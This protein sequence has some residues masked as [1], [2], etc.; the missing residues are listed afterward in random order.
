[1]P[2]T[3]LGAVSTLVS[4]TERPCE[5]DT[6]ILIS[7]HHTKEL[8]LR[9]ARRLGAHSGF[10]ASLTGEVCVGGDFL[11]DLQT[12]PCRP[13]PCRFVALVPV[14]SLS[15]NGDLQTA[16]RR[17]VRTRDAN[18]AV[19]ASPRVLPVPQSWSDPGRIQG[20]ACAVWR[21]DTAEPLPPTP[22]R[23]VL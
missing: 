19:L 13:S 4:D 23:E 11:S 7:G 10:S 17:L 5:M 14:L 16:C 20:P 3:A 21:L 18:H 8:S 22:T 9:A 1:M 12:Q 6:L 2:S 15:G